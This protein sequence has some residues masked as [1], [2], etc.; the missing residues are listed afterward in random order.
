MDL[1]EAVRYYIY[2]STHEQLEWGEV[3]VEFDFDNSIRG[4]PLDI[5][6]KGIGIE[7]PGLDNQQLE[8]IKN[9]E[10]YMVK[11]HFGEEFL[12]A[13]LKNAWS[14]VIYEEGKMIF[15][16]GFTIDVISPQDRLKLSGIIET[17]R[18]NL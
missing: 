17:I 2:K 1:R 15:K 14:R 5:S 4:R 11:L 16:G 9:C 10:N 12:L 13:G 8:M 3:H 18:N 7:I 6:L